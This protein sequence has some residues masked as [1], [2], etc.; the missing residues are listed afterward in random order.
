MLSSATVNPWGTMDSQADSA[1]NA[2]TM[3]GVMIDGRYRVERVLAESGR[4]LTL[5]ANRADIGQRVVIKILR[6]VPGQG[7]DVAQRFGR[8]IRATASVEHPN[9]VA[10]FDAGS[11]PDGRPFFAMEHIDGVLLSD[12]IGH[13]APMPPERAYGIVRQITAAVSAAH[14]AGVFHRDLKPS[15]IFISTRNGRRDFVT[16]SDF[17]VAKLVDEAHALTIAGTLIG[18]SAYLSP[19]K[20]DPKFV[21]PEGFNEDAAGDVYAIG[22][23]AF[24][25][26][27]GR[28]PLID[29]SL[30]RQVLKRIQ[31]VPDW[32]A[33]ARVPDKLESAVEALLDSDVTKRPASAF[34]ALRVLDQ[35][36]PKASDWHAS[37]PRAR[38]PSVRR[39]SVVT[40]KRPQPSTAGD[41]VVAPPASVE[42]TA[43]PWPTSTKTLGRGMLEHGD[44]STVLALVRGTTDDGVFVSVFVRGQTIASG[45]SVRLTFPGPRATG[46]KVSVE[47]KVVG[48]VGNDGRSLHLYVRLAGGNRRTEYTDLRRR[49]STR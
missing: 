20:G 33:D 21:A 23:I 36:N 7:P 2:G 19:E 26:L 27:V 41:S 13:D 22:C 5:M 47:G 31:D 1:H 8:E 37:A 6:E 28:P 46:G 24:E 17:A 15:S 34:D 3:E 4:T 29:D 43:P 40:P 18:S 25:L 12:I 9:V 14:A 10:I 32:P 45:E 30:L 11:M 48:N 16:V 49:W 42:G 35:L 38:V 44:G 39:S